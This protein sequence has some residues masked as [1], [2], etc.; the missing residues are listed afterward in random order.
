MTCIFELK[1]YIVNAVNIIF[2]PLKIEV[3]VMG[4]GRR[5]QYEEL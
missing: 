2:T 4:D 3:Q 5:T 1:V